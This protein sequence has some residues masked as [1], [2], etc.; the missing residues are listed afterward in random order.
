MSG[1]YDLDVNLI[2]SISSILREE[3]S[4][5]DKVFKSAMEKFGI[6]SPADLGTEEEKKEFFDYVDSQYV[7]KDESNLSEMNFSKKQ[8]AKLLS[9]ARAKIE[10]GAKKIS[11]DDSLTAW[12]DGR[13]TLSRR[14]RLMSSL[15]K[16]EVQSILKEA[17]LDRRKEWEI[18]A[19]NRNAENRQQVLKLREKK[20]QAELGKGMR[21]SAGYVS[22][23]PS[24]EIMSVV[25]AGT[26]KE[27]FEVSKSAKDNQWSVKLDSIGGVQS[28]E[29]RNFPVKKFKTLKQVGDYIRKFNFAEKLGEG[30]YYTKQFPS[31]PYRLVDNAD[32]H[33]IATTR[34]PSPTYVEAMENELEEQNLQEMSDEAKFNKLRNKPHA[35]IKKLGR[36]KGRNVKMDYVVSYQ[37]KD[38]AMKIDLGKNKYQYMITPEGEKM[39]NE[40]I[41]IPVSG[42]ASSGPDSAL[43]H[44]DVIDVPKRVDVI[45]DIQEMEGD[46]PI[47]TYRLWCQYVKDSVILPPMSEMGAENIEDLLAYEIP[48]VAEAVTKA[49][50]LPSNSEMFRGVPPVSD[51][52]EAVKSLKGLKLYYPTMSAAMQDT[53]AA[54]S[55]MGYEVD[56]DDYFTTV[57]TGP[58]KPSVGKT[59]RYSLILKRGEKEVRERLQ[60]QIYGMEGGKFEL[61]AYIA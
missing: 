54:A 41:S 8:W 10:T 38:L 45:K 25:R 18:D 20:Y 47:T 58:G 3:E 46:E 21:V 36:G 56:D 2:N 39:L 12:K 35:E 9:A 48:G 28:P 44:R 23:M 59:N 14:G 4:E 11:P 1:I 61:N 26:S 51:L 53:L 31:R 5:Y 42:I 55:R 27:T 50:D 7:A 32:V 40:G 6:S 57:T 17:Y 33:T 37:G 19:D 60:I 24:Y 43:Y 52:S 34:K 49:L 16:E 30:K 29:H 22:R 15:D 13:V